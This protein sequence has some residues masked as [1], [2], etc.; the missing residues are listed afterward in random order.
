MAHL[1]RTIDDYRLAVGCQFQLPVVMVVSLHH[2][3]GTVRLAALHNVPRVGEDLQDPLLA[4]LGVQG[5]D[6]HVLQRDDALGRSLGRVLEVVETPVV[7]DKP[8]SLPALPAS[9]LTTREQ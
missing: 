2:G 1:R 4:V 9:S 3:A 5:A 8:P 7:E 6:A